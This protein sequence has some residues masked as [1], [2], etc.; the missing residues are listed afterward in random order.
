MAGDKL[1]R[2]NVQMQNIKGLA[3]NSRIALAQRVPAATSCATANVAAKRCIPDTGDPFDQGQRIGD[4]EGPWL[5]RVTLKYTV[6]L[7]P[8]SR[9]RS[10]G[11]CDREFGQFT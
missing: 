2:L 8:L 7:L 10:L 11:Q 4:A 6:V 5:K 3:A 9:K 1:R